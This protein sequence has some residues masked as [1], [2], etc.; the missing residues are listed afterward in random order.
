MAGMLAPEDGPAV[1][2]PSAAAFFDL[3]N[4]LVRG[5]SLFHLAR[6]LAARRMVSNHEI[7]R[8][9]WHQLA[10]RLRGEHAVSLDDTRDAALSFATGH[11]V[12]ELRSICED[13]FHQYL[14]GK[15]WP[16][17]RALVDEHHAAG[18]RVWLVTA[19]P[20]ELAETIAHHV[21][22]AG[23]LGTLSEAV[24]GVYTGRLAGPPLHG[25]AKAEAVA[26][27]AA[28][29]G[30][31]LTRCYAYSDSANDLPLLSLVGHPV[32]VNPDARLRRHARA[33]GWRIVDHR[34]GRRTS[35]GGAAA[36]GVL[37][38]GGALVVGIA[39]LWDARRR[40]GTVKNSCADAR[41]DA[42]A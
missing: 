6:G 27:L 42:R 36:V 41:A 15:I 23:A 11:Q 18:R 28:S 1:S 12:E 9:A 24:D 7:A 26:K 25:P 34:T 38:G 31:D 22:M 35:I 39:K 20:H 33:H 5:A 4:T 29:E 21:G 16:G 40:H 14:F 32:A 19:A 2:D 37:T 17:T 10:F 13:V 3:D 30:L 8:F